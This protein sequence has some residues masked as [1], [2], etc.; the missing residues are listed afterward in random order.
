MLSMLL[1]KQSR[2]TLAALGWVKVWTNLVMDCE[3]AVAHYPTPRPPHYRKIQFF[4]VWEPPWGW[5]AA[6]TG[7]IGARHLMETTA[8]SLQP[9][10]LQPDV[11]FPAELLGSPPSR[12]RPSPGSTTA[13][14]H[15]CS[16]AHRRR[17]QLLLA[18]TDY[19]V[20]SWQAARQALP[21]VGRGGAPQ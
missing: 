15:V 20:G 17:A 16:F 1:F 14:A 3:S 8:A 19:S 6:P 7:W 13:V 9:L 11:K 2:V 10:F 12:E 5:L 4:F 18:Q 21:Q